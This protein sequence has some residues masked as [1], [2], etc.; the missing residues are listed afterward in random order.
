MR[1]EK[2]HV[3]A[4]EL[5]DYAAKTEDVLGF[6]ISGSYGKG[7][8]H[9]RSDLDPVFITKEGCVARVD[10]EILA[11]HD[12]GNCD[13]CIY[14]ISEFESLSTKGTSDMGSDRYD[15]AHIKVAVDK[16][17]GRIQEIVDK[18][19]TLSEE[20]R[21]F[22]GAGFLDGYINGFFRSLKAARQ[23]W[24]VAQAL[25]AAE[26]IH[27]G[28]SF[29]FAVEHRTLPFYKYLE[30]ELAT[31]PLTFPM[32]A[33]VLISTIQRI[34]S[35]ADVNAQIEW[36]EAIA[37]HAKENGFAQNIADWDG[38]PEVLASEFKLRRE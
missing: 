28:L 16:T 2:L 21:L 14:T 20:E 22:L 37:R 31:Y 38:K 7:M 12:M 15:Y 33:D 4:R 8:I 18:R 34:L 23:G 9:E 35:T 3:F 6:Y 25:E 11:Q 30:W 36:F 32:P 10:A 19:G 26:G 1:I 29:L 17:G 24:H 27:Y 5:Q 13:L